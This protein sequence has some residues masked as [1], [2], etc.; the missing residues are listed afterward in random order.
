MTAAA[1]MGDIARVSAYYQ[2]RLAF[3]PVGVEV[4]RSG[5]D[6]LTLRFQVPD[7]IT[8]SP[9]VDMLL[10]LPLFVRDD[11]PEGEFALRFRSA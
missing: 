2:E 7:G 10:G 8:P 9:G 5:W 11:L 4:G 6:A 1:L 3:W